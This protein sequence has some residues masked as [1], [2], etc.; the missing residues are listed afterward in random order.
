MIKITIKR[1]NKIRLNPFISFFIIKIIYFF[2]FKLNIIRII[3]IRLIKDK[4][5]KVKLKI[6]NEKGSII[7][8]YIIKETI[9]PHI[10]FFI[11]PKDEKSNNKDMK[12]RGIITN[13]NIAP[14]PSLLIIPP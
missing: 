2:C 13:I 10:L 8:I 6:E 7:I 3:P 5:Q 4:T 11:I 12:K 1:I 14:A 9:F